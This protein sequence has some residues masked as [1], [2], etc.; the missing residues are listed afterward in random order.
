MRQNGRGHEAAKAVAQ[1]V[2]RRREGGEWERG[3]SV[4]D[5]SMPRGMAEYR[6]PGR[7]Q[8]R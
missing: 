1:D 3:G 5:L 4:A 2:E 6:F 8:L 7:L